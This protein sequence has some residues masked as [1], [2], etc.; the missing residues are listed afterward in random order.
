MYTD[1]AQRDGSVA[2]K[3]WVPLDIILTIGILFYQIFYRYVEASERIY[4]D[5]E[6]IGQGKKR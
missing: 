3:M 6:K 2:R 5:Y 4:E 1:A